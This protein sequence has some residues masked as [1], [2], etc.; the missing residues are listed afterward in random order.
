MVALCHLEVVK[1][2]SWLM[3][4]GQIISIYF[5]FNG[6]LCGECSLEDNVRQSFARAH[7]SIIFL[8]Q[9]FLSNLLI[10]S[11]Q[12]P[13]QPASSFT[14]AQDYLYIYISEHFLSPTKWTIKYTSHSSDLYDFLN[15]CPLEPSL[16][17]PEIPGSRSVGKGE[18]SKKGGKST[19]M[20]YYQIDIRDG[21]PINDHFSVQPVWRGG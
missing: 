15:Y 4:T 20:A 7:M 9:T 10:C 13:D 14:N 18:W 5:I 1:E 21:G 17:K 11:H 16:R 3:S 19:V 12:A 8:S 6:C 2:T